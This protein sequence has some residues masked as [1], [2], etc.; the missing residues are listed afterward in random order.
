M[1]VCKCWDIVSM[2]IVFLLPI[3]SI[4]D[5]GEVWK[6]HNKTSLEQDIIG[7]VWYI[8]T[9]TEFLG[10]NEGRPERTALASTSLIVWGIGKK[11]MKVTA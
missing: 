3:F 6:T 10:Q 8:K 5:D 2:C 7:P 11:S 9:Y 1:L 4:N